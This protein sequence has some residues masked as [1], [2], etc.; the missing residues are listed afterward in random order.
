VE[1]LARRWNATVEAIIPYL[2][3]EIARNSP[4]PTEQKTLRHDSVFGCALCADKV[5]AFAPHL[6]ERI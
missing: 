6:M 2:S 4:F 5:W 3:M 1:R